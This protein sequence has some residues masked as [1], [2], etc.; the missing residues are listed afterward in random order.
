MSITNITRP[1][2]FSEMM[3]VYSASHTKHINAHTKWSGF[4]VLYSRWY[5]Y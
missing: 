5:V 4:L 1:I 2:M 3:A